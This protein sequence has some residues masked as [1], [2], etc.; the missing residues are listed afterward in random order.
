MAGYTPV[1]S[2]VFTGTLCGKY[3]DTAAWLFLLALA[4]KNGVVDMTPQYISSVT[5]MPVTELL[6]CIGRFMEPDPHSRSKAEEGRRLLPVESGRDWGWKIVNFDHYREKAR[7]QAKAAREVESG[8][9]KSRMNDRRRPPSTAADPLSNAN[10][11]TNTNTD[12]EEEV[13]RPEVAAL[14]AIYPKRSGSQPWRL[15]EQQCLQRIG[16]GHTWQQILSGA[17]RYAAW[18]GATGK[19]GMET[20]MQAKT[21]CGREKHFLEQW[22]PPSNGTKYTPPPGWDDEEEKCTPTT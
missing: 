8:E 7:L 6:A 2:S 14:K 12:T 20:V 3:P 21:F 16:E 10:T 15:A 17:E 19:V 9:N 5:G 22:E 1:F 11:Y 18:C 4:D 13:A